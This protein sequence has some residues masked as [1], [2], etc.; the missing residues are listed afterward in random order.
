MEKDSRKLLTKR[1]LGN[2]I[3]IRH[4]RLQEK[5]LDCQ[6]KENTKTQYCMDNNL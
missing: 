6:E 3:N 1:K 5:N 2:S 4:N